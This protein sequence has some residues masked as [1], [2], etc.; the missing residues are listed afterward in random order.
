M[1][2]LSIYF[3]ASLA[4]LLA[5]DYPAPPAA[6]GP[7]MP[8]QAATPAG[9]AAPAGASAPLYF[10]NRKLKGDRL[11]LNVSKHP[12]RDA[13]RSPSVPPAREI[14]IEPAR[15]PKILVGC[16]SAFSPLLVS[17]SVN[18]ASQCLAEKAM[19]RKSYAAVRG[20]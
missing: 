18:F 20:E 3:F 6:V 7:A 19:A 2:G 11:P 1:R 10:V 15:Q 8:G 17:A 9:F 5:I 16:D 12:K 14:P 4:I 13:V